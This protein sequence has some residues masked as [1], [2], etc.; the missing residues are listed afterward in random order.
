MKAGIDESEEKTFVAKAV[1]ASIRIATIGVLVFWCF[2]IVAPFIIPIV[3]GMIIAVAAYPAQKKL[4][5]LFGGRK[6]LAATVL[7]LLMVLA[8]L[9]PATL[10]AQAVISGVQ[11]VAEQ[12]KEGKLGMPPPPPGIET[13]PIIG[14]QLAALWSG[15]VQNLE[16]AIVHFAPQIKEVGIWLLSAA[17]GMGLAVLLFIVSIVVAGVFLAYA[18]G[19]SRFAHKL[20]TRLAGDRG[21]D[22]VRTAESTVRSVA[23]GVLGVAIIQAS[24]AGL[25]LL[26]AGIP[27]A[28]FWAFLCLL[29]TVMQIGPLPVLLPAAVYMF[30]TADTLPAIVFT[31]WILVV[32]VSDNI[33]RPLLL[34][35]GVDTP[36]IVVLLGTLGGFITS[37]VVGLFV[38][39]VVVTLGYR[40]FLAWLERSA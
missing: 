33:L 26:V 23:R 4:E 6:G 31:I 30:A 29:L 21:E 32:G 19:G 11:G 37:G 3:W 39:A 17:G 15:S 38:G 5:T 7:S 14:K 35:R 9:V 40:L 36:M 16:K 24:L 25:G 18:D 12:L 1:E 34:G 22:L 13:W 2:Q 10:L 28:G 20:A 27:G 8:L